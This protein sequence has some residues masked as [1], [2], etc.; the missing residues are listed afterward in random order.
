METFTSFKSWMLPSTIG[1]NPT[2]SLLWWLITKLK[3]FA[4]T[5][6]PLNGF[7]HTQADETITKIA[8]AYTGVTLLQRVLTWNC[9]RILWRDIA[10]ACTILT[11]HDCSRYLV[12]LLQYELLGE[13]FNRNSLSLFNVISKS[14][15]FFVKKA[16][17]HVIVFC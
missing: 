1:L 7:N 12:T 15:Y 14:F 13:T 10:A 17:Y 16:Y 9:C 3:L 11:W 5:V 6:S 4:D 8:A 2:E